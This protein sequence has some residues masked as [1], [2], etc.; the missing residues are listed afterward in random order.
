RD[1][2]AWVLCENKSRA[3]SAREY[4]RWFQ[5]LLCGKYT[6]SFAKTRCEQRSPVDRDSAPCREQRPYFP[7]HGL[8]WAPRTQNQR[9]WTLP[10]D[11]R[12]DQRCFPYEVQPGWCGSVDDERA[13]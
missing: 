11:D 6:R 13:A 12:S 9:R 4:D 10:T 2:S 3:D 8:R 1:K 5:H 7:D